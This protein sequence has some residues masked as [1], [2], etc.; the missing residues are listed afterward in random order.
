MKTILQIICVVTFLISFTV[1]ALAVYFVLFDKWYVVRMVLFIFFGTIMMI[2][3]KLLPVSLRP[4]ARPVLLFMVLVCIGMCLYSIVLMVY[5]A[6]NLDMIGFIKGGLKI[7]YGVPGI[8]LY[9]SAQ[10]YDE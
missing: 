8:A 7:V 10:N 6:V 5:Y 1:S 4:I 2:T 3:G 9:G